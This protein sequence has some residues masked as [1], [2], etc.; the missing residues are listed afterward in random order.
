MLPEIISDHILN[1]NGLFALLALIP[2]IAVYLIRPRSIEKP[3]PTLMFL[4]R[5]EKAHTNKALFRTFFANFLFLIQLLAI[6]GLIFAIASPVITMPGKEQSEHTILV[7]DSSASMKTASGTSTRFEQAVSEAKSNIQGKVTLITAQH[8]PSVLLDKASR[9]E[10]E[11]VLSTLKAHDTSSNIGE[12][13]LLAG[14]YAQKGSTIVAIS[15]FAQ[16]SGIEP[17]IAAQTLRARGI[18][19]QMISI[20]SPQNNIGFVNLVLDKETT[21]AYVKN[22]YQE[23]K[24]IKV[25]YTSDD[26][27]T[28]DQVKEVL[29]ESVEI[30]DFATT[31]GNNKLSIDSSDALQTDN[32]LHT[33][34]PDLKKVRV[35]LISNI[36]ADKDTNTKSCAQ[37]SSRLHSLSSQKKFSEQY[38]LVKLLSAF[39]ATNRIICDYSFPPLIPDS[40]KL[41]QYDI[42]I[43]Y[44]FNEKDITPVSYRDIRN[45]AEKGAHIIITAD[46]SLASEDLKALL[47]VTIQGTQ[48]INATVSYVRTSL[49]RNVNFESTDIKRI[50]QAQANNN[51]EQIASAAGYALIAS[52]QIKEGDTTY[53]GMLE[54]YSDFHTLPD[55]VIFFGQLF[56]QLT[57]SVDLKDY[58]FQ[59]GTVV[60]DGQD[61]QLL[62]DIGTKTVGS[63]TVSSNLLSAPESDVG[64]VPDVKIAG[65]TQNQTTQGATHQLKIEPYLILAALLFLLLELIYLKTRG[66]I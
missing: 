61:K 7:L 46:R 55:Y 34:V 22:Y 37:L 42:I 41:E 43:L 62:L 27:K 44:K 66:D 16:T 8:A 48:N 14:D 53:Y 1:Q 65:S 59:T 36:D 39:S 11:G 19:V 35:L 32:V 26:G 31:Q 20:G 9:K 38:S 15:D 5:D 13:M 10:A 56:E 54:D 25:T 33:S 24:A 29:A 45:A 57:A 28:T 30:F 51:S 50:V 17:I 63:K 4:I 3:I 60:V 52:A 23:Q 47:P 58:N 64:N 2:F 6:L 21:K 49:T 12:A 40:Q 18:Q